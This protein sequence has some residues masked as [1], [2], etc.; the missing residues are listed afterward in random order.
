MRWRKANWDVSRIEHMS[1]IS[2]LNLI[3][4]ITQ[5]KRMIGRQKPSA[6][7]MAPNC[8]VDLGLA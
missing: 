6:A 1:S 3:P 8:P 4:T 2:Y 5:N 7:V